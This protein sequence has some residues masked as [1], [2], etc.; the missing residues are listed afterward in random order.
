MLTPAQIRE[1]EE[2]YLFVQNTRFLTGMPCE[3]QSLDILKRANIM[4]WLSIITKNNLSG[5]M[6]LLFI[7]QNYRLLLWRQSNCL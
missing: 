1:L 5:K 3:M 6:Q 7:D 4:A 2:M